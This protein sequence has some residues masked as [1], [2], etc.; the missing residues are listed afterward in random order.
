[1]NGWMAPNPCCI[2]WCKR[3]QQKSSVYSVRRVVLER[4]TEVKIRMDDGG[5]NGATSICFEV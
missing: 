3:I 4:I 2:R 1:M 5:C